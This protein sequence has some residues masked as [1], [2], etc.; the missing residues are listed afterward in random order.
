[1][2]LQY[3]S[4][5]ILKDFLGILTKSADKSWKGKSQHVPKLRTGGNSLGSREPAGTS[6]GLSGIPPC[7]VMQQ[8]QELLAL[9]AE[10]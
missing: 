3:Q 8:G 5:L 6:P 2:G 4:L 9:G 1:M 7:R 10:Q